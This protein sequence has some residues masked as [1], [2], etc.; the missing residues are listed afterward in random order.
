MFH[1]SS[2]AALRPHER[3]VFGAALL[4]VSLA[5]VL[6]GCSSNSDPGR[7][8]TAS[9]SS[10]SNL[11]PQQQQVLGFYQCMRDNGV[12]IPDP[13]N[14]GIIRLNGIDPNDPAVAA[15]LNTCRSS[16]PGG[17]EPPKPDAKALK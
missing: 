7:E 14:D 17:G 3:R 2:H 15:A 1:R 10:N 8:P 13:D 12:D 5:A 11:S 16:M 6:T 9:P 4:A